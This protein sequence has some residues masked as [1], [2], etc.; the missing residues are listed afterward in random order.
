MK[1]IITKNEGAK[2]LFPQNR[3]SGI[4]ATNG[5]GY[6]KNF[7]NVYVKRLFDE[8]G[9]IND[10]KFQNEVKIG[11]KIEIIPA[12]ICPTVNLYDETQVVSKGKLFKTVPILARG[13]V[14]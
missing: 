5:F 10:E 14:K 6:I 9:I 2:A 3:N 4:C 1:V 12:H 8:H 7:D 13:K 11:E